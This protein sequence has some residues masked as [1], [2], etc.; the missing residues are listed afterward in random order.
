VFRRITFTAVLAASLV[1]A[2][3]MAGSA[4]AAPTTPILK[5]MPF[6]VPSDQP[7][8][9]TPSGLDSNGNPNLSA[10]EFTLFNL[11][12]PGSKTVA[13]RPFVLPAS[14]TLNTL[15]PGVSS[16]DEYALCVRT[17]EVTNSLQVL[18]SYRSCAVFQVIYKLELARIVNKYV[19][20]NPDPG[21][22]MCGLAAAVTD[23]PV[24]G[25]KLQAVAVRDPAPIAGVRIDARGEVA[26][27]G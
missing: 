19:A 27:V 4:L 17:I 9:W 25:E 16:G 12:V 18:F 23:D 24:I 13:Y 6:Y 5:P 1:A 11:T 3:A 22:I 15:F 26:I 21:C 20:Y 8:G 7:V 10:Y 2:L 14:T